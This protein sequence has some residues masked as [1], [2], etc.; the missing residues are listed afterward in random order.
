MTRINIPYNP[1]PGFDRLSLLL[2]LLSSTEQML[3]IGETQEG[4]FF[5]ELSRIPSRF[6]QQTNSKLQQRKSSLR[7]AK[8]PLQQQR[9]IRQ[10]SCRTRTY[11][12]INPSSHVFQAQSHTVRLHERL[13]LV[14]SLLQTV[15]SLTHIRIQRIQQT[16]GG[17]A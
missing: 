7:A 8:R 11:L 13:H 4:T 16:K 5:F 15:L 12:F 3:G 2:Y 14:S 9:R 6:F 10:Q 1:S 17:L